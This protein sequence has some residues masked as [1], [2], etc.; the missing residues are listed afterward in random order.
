MSRPQHS[1]VKKYLLKMALNL[2]DDFELKLRKTIYE[3][4]PKVITR[5]GKN[6]CFKNGI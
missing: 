4:K 6:V 5:N 1:I 3:G 2:S